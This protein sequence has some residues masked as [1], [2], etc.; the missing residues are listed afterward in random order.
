L[1][2]FNGYLLRTILAAGMT[3]NRWATS[4]LL[5]VLGLQQALYECLAVQ[6]ESGASDAGKGVGGSANRQRQLETV[7]KELRGVLM[8]GEGA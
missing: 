1:A 3:E 7:W 2:A 8:R 4:R 6:L 5:R